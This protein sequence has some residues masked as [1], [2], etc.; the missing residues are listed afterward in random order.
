MTED[1]SNT[2]GGDTQATLGVG[3]LGDI[4][5][6]HYGDGRWHLGFEADVEEVCI[7]VEETNDDASRMMTDG[8]EKVAE[9]LTTRLHDRAQSALAP[10]A[11]DILDA[12]STSILTEDSDYYYLSSH[13][14]EVESLVA[15]DVLSQK[16]ADILCS[17]Y[18][19]VVCVK[20]RNDAPEHRWSN[21][22]PLGD[23]DALV[24]KKTESEVGETG[25]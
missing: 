21:P 11:D 2:N 1:E 9:E 22:A 16:E 6:V 12:E 15:D 25:E 14:G 5:L 20:W 8:G 17:D 13:P 3:D 4:D 24:L 19:S 18:Y 10:Y 23:G 7:V